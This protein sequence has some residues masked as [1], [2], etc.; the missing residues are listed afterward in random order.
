MKKQ[1]FSS[2]MS[3]SKNI[4]DWVMFIVVLS[5]GCFFS[6]EPVLL[7]FSLLRPV[8]ILITFTLLILLLFSLDY[9]LSSLAGFLKGVCIILG[10]W[11]GLKQGKLSSMISEGW[12]FIPSLFV[13]PQQRGDLICLIVFLSVF[14][15]GVLN[16]CW[17]MGLK[18]IVFETLRIQHKGDMSFTRFLKE[19]KAKDLFAL[20]WVKFKMVLH[21]VLFMGV[22][23]GIK[24][25]MGAEV[26]AI[27]TEILKI[28]WPCAFV[29]SSIPVCLQNK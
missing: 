15:I 22:I 9:V 5:M 27:S 6:V 21:V 7:V 18:H 12:D 8:W 2:K 4:L 11:F 19:Q 20:Q 16:L 3:L 13:L 14:W 24:I 23:A 29:V 17:H 25:C 1:L 26:L 10:V 28:F